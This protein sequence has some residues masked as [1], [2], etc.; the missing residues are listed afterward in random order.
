MSNQT[1]SKAFKS[2]DQD[3]ITSGDFT[4]SRRQITKYKTIE[5]AITNGFYLENE[6]WNTTRVGLTKIDCLSL[7]NC[8]IDVSNS[9]SNLPDIQLEKIGNRNVLI[10]TRN[11]EDLLDLHKGK[12]FANPVLNGTTNSDTNLYVGNFANIAFGDLPLEG[13]CRDDTKAQAGF[14]R[15]I[16]IYPFNTLVDIDEIGNENFTESKINSVLFPNSGQIQNTSWGE[17]S[18]GYVFDPY[19]KLYIDLCD[20]QNYEKG[21][22]AERIRN[23]SRIDFRWLIE[24]WDIVKGNMLNG[25]AYPTRINFNQQF[26]SF[27]TNNN[28]LN[29]AP[30]PNSNSNKLIASGQKADGS[31]EDLKCISKEQYMY[32][33]IAICNY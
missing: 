4:I 21:S 31:N 15:Y 29:L 1:A 20:T 24:Y 30:L 2:I 33:R 6:K 22:L 25:F 3:I 18:P 13:S 26:T 23:N 16:F 28:V 12:K 17:N 11:Y 32:W 8:E 27:T 10:S 9:N 7:P 14:N 5:K 19:G